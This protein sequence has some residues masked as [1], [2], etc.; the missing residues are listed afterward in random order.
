MSE[1]Y[2]HLVRGRPNVDARE[3]R[4]KGK[5]IEA[6]PIVQTMLISCKRHY[7]VP[8]VAT[9]TLVFVL[10]GGT[11]AMPMHLAAIEGTRNKDLEVN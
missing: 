8:A 7:V 3:K 10:A 1:D 5:S 2:T 4:Q 11:H 6:T 9:L